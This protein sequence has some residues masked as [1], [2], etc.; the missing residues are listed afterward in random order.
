MAREHVVEAD[1]RE[2]QR[3][4]DGDASD[5]RGESGGAALGV[6]AAAEEQPHGRERDQ[7]G[8]RRGR[9]LKRRL[10]ADE[11]LGRQL[12]A[13]RAQGAA[14]LAPPEDVRRPHEPGEDDPGRD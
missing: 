2:Q 9:E 13:P 6:V 3:R 12:N 10:V 4:H 8:D 14:D 11:E 1:D 7:R 5:D